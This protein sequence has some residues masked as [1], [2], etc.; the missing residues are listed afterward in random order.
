MRE[1]AGVLRVEMVVREAA[2]TVVADW[3][4]HP[5]NAGSRTRWV[6]WGPGRDGMMQ[7]VGHFHAAIAAAALKSY[8]KLPVQD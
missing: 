2:V 8:G 7:V 6:V 4:V 5:T 1:V 3:S